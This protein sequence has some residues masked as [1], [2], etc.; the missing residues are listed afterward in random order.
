[1]YSKYRDRSRKTLTMKHLDSRWK[2]V[3]TTGAGC[4]VAVTSVTTAAVFIFISVSRW[5]RGDT[6]LYPGSVAVTLQPAS[7]I[8]T[9]NQKEVE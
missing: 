2:R 5:V 8:S 9:D 7:L 1:M 3:T 4:P 6:S